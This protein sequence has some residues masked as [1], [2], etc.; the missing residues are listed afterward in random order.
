MTESLMSVF[1]VFRKR[2]DSETDGSESSDGN[3]GKKSKMGQTRG[4]PSDGGKGSPIRSRVK[5]K[6]SKAVV[7]QTQKETDSSS[8]EENYKRKRNFDSEASDTSPAKR[9]V[10]SKVQKSGSQ[11]DARSSDEGKSKRG[12]RSGSRGSVPGRRLDR[13]GMISPRD[14]SRRDRRNRS[15]SPAIRHISPGRKQHS[16][17]LRNEPE[18]DSGVL[19]IDHRK[20]GGAGRGHRRPGP[21]SPDRNFGRGDY[22][23][24]FEQNR[25]GRSPPGDRIRREQPIRDWPRGDARDRGRGYDM[26]NDY[27]D[28]RLDNRN[29]PQRG[30]SLSPPNQR[31]RV[32][33]RGEER[34]DRNAERMQ[35]PTQRSVS[36][37]SHMSRSLSVS[38]ERMQQHLEEELGKKRKAVGQKRKVTPS[39]SKNSKGRGKISDD[40]QD[41]R[42]SQTTKK[43]K[44]KDKKKAKDA[45]DADDSLESSFERSKKFL[46][47]HSDD[48]EIPEPEHT[49]ILSPPS[50]KQKSKRQ[51]ETSESESESPQKSK[52]SKE[53]NTNT[54][55][56]PAGRR[57]KK[58]KKGKGLK[59]RGSLSPHSAG[60]QKSKGKRT[61]RRSYSRSPSTMERSDRER[62]Q[63]SERSFGRHHD[64]AQFES[65]P[66]SG[67]ITDSEEEG[68]QAMKSQINVSWVSHIQFIFVLLIRK[69]F[70][71]L[72][73]R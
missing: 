66:E 5:K 26:G 54:E 50:T 22:N 28:R 38:P 44:S 25:F 6:N 1:N 57:A 36:P 58:S 46:V 31:D 13:E 32:D 2:H 49:E 12:Q 63:S 62:S 29:R 39:E 64:M 70:C 30:R 56:V 73:S 60:G 68:K 67:E 34:Y 42:K 7:Q 19:Y 16:P 65:E 59:Q 53:N 33:N 71:L 61:S 18:Q 8:A 20:K 9:S 72:S 40:D 21:R 11:R 10:V 37:E 4:S 48:F 15:L 41:E 17:E 3:I 23:R 47:S 51:R 14:D 35:R 55:S 45:S 24:S 43:S 69:V 52:R 27:D